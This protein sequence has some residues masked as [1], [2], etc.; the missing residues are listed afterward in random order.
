MKR[1]TIIVIIVIITLILSMVI[2]IGIQY[3]ETHL[4]K[5]RVEIMYRSI[6]LDNHEFINKTETINFEALNDTLAYNDAFVKFYSFQKAYE[7]LAQENPESESLLDKPLEFIIYDSD[8]KNITD[9]MFITK[10]SFLLY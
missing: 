8:G 7:K 9:I 5:Y 2:V 4:K 3:S 10:G 6:N 1:K